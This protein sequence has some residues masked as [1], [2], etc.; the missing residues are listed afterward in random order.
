MHQ[1]MPPNGDVVFVSNKE[2]LMLVVVQL[3]HLQ[4]LPG[5]MS[6]APKICCNECFILIVCLLGQ[7]VQVLKSV[8]D[9]FNLQS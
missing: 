6:H 4:L 9:C 3:F 2:T 7:L 5:M 8:A 1:E